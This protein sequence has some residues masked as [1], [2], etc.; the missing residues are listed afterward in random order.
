LATPAEQLARVGAALPRHLRYRI[1]GTAGFLDQR[2]LLFLAPPPPALR[3]R[4]DLDPPG[5]LPSA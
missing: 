1:A 4:D 3:L 5:H 2:E